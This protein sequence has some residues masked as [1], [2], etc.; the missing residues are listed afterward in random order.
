MHSKMNDAGAALP[1]VEE[2]HTI[3]GEGANTG[4]AAYFIRLGGCDVRCPWCDSRQTWDASAARRESI[5]DI[6]ARAAASG[7]PA[8][9][10]TGGEPTIHDLGPLAASLRE[11]GMQV[12]IET[13][14]VHPVTGSPDWVCLSP[15]RHR[16]PVDEAC[17]AADEL[18]V[19][20]AGEDDLRWAEECAARVGGGCRLYLQPEWSSR[21]E[22]ADLIVEYVKRNPGWRISLQTHKYL[23]IP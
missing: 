10:I 23:D 3:Q 5:V 22:V 15:K 14:G 4:R 9:V 16:P 19:V 20:V 17:A 8:A 18:K 1:V 2:F 7:A 21:R 12:W 13:S 11:A 6:A